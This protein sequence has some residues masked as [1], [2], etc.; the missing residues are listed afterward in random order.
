MSL[1]LPNRRAFIGGALALFAAPAIVRAQ[2]LMPVKPTFYE[3]AIC[4]YSIGTDQLFIRLDV[5]QGY[6]LPV[7]R[8]GAISVDAALRRLP[9]EYVKKFRSLRP[10]LGVQQCMTWA[11]PHE[12]ADHQAP[13]WQAAIS[14]EKS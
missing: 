7:P 2:S 4:N 9:P 13:W 8:F 14:G 6:P 11:V 3:R 12:S 5:Q 10:A 1:I